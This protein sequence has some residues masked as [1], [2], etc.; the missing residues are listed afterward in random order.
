VI[1]VVFRYTVQT[2]GRGRRW[3]IL[4]VAK[5][6]QIIYKVKINLQGTTFV[7]GRHLE[8]GEDGRF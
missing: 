3:Q 7:T 2:L 4:Q 6:G 1:I 8:E 5:R